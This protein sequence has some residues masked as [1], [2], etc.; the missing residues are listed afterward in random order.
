MKRAVCLPQGKE[1]VKR[2]PERRRKAREMPHARFLK[3]I[4]QW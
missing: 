2:E 4:V 3:F 1:I